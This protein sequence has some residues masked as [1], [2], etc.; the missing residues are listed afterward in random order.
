M[1]KL[2][3]V[4][5]EDIIRETIVTCIDWAEIG[6]EVV[7]AEDGE[8]ALEIARQCL[9]AAV[10]TDV[11]MP[12]M[13]GLELTRA[14]RREL[15]D[16]LVMVLSGHDEFR[17]AQQALELGVLE[18]ITKPILP[19]DFTAAMIRL[20]QRVQ[21]RDRQRQGIEKLQSQLHHSLPLLR[22]RFLNLMVNRP[23]PAEEISRS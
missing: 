3:L 15:P 19:G 12:I 14:L 7:E 20:R 6:F 16:T 10:V 5:D 2:L 8:A 4:E 9:P 21:E 13:D 22:E 11:K 23:L 18:Y 17:Y 1:Y